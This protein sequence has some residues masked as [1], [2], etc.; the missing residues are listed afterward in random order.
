M[1]DATVRP[2]ANRTLLAGVLAT[3]GMLFAAFTAAYLERR[4]GGDWQRTALPG[5]LWIN[6]LVIVASS[7]TLEAGRRRAGRGWIRLTAVLGLAF[8]AGQVVA[9]RRLAAAGVFLPTRPHA[10][11]FYTLSAVHGVHLL[12]G[13]VALGAG[14][15]RPAVL[16]LCAAY[17]HFVGA[18]WL[19]VLAVLNLL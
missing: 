19:Y 9:W 3:V 15:R 14:L 18:V 8:L 10:S 1:N 2:D 13:I 11:F 4:G 16:G 5:I 6:T 17:W 12:G 7:V